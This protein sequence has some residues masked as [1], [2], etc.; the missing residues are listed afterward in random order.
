MHTRQSAAPPTAGSADDAAPAGPA[1][2][3]RRGPV[4][5]H[6]TG[7]PPAPRPGRFREG[8]GELHKRSEANPTVIEP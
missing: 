5:Q 7:P 3:R 2:P 4:N 1:A 8:L 6:R